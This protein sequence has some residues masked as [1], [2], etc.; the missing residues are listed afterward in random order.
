MEFSLIVFLCFFFHAIK[1]VLDLWCLRGP[2]D[3]SEFIKA[4]KTDTNSLPSLS[5]VATLNYGK[6]SFTCVLWILWTFSKRP[7]C[8]T[9]LSE[10][11]HHIVSDFSA[12]HNKKVTLNILK[13]SNLWYG[14]LYRFAFHLICL[15]IEFSLIIC[16]LF[17]NFFDTRGLWP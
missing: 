2:A 11:S 12:L 8:N 3:S 17:L 14:M 10:A 5:T 1:K 13:K 7:F 15:K 9:K 4:V 16:L 6:C